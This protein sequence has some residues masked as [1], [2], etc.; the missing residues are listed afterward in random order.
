LLYIAQDI[1]NMGPLWVYWCF[2][3]QRYCGSLLPSVKSKK[4]P[5]TCLA[6]C[7]RDLAQNSHIKL[8]YQLHD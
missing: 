8:I 7:I 3:M 6:N 4:H 5:E 2:V 1:Q